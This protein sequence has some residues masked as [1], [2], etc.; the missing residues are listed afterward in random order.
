MDP[1]WIAARAAGK[2]VSIAL[3]RAGKYVLTASGVA[4]I[5]PSSDLKAGLVAATGPAGQAWLFGEC[6]DVQP[7]EGPACP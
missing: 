2:L 6:A 5:E 4:R 3:V 7:L 1:R